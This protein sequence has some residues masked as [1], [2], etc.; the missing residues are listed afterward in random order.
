MAAATAVGLSESALVAASVTRSAPPEKSVARCRKMR[1][2]AL[3]PSRSRTST[4]RTPLVVPSEISALRAAAE[5]LFKMA[6]QAYAT[7]SDP[8]LRRRY[9][10][11]RALVNVAWMARQFTMDEAGRLHGP[12]GSWLMRSSL[13]VLARRAG[14]QSVPSA[15]ISSARSYPNCTQLLHFCAHAIDAR[16]LVCL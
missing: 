11:Q 3:S 8:A 12:H 4:A 16:K 7:L 2:G 10:A 14:V 13:F 6:A 5:A 1:E 15:C 9:D